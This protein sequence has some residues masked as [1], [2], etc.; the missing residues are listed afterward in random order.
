[1]IIARKLKLTILDEDKEKRKEQYKFIRDSQYAQYQGLNTC[2]GYLMSEYFRCNREIKSCEFKETQ[3]NITNSSPIFEGIEFGKGIDS[4]SLIT[5]KVKSDFK[6]ALKNGLASGERSCT[7][8]KRTFPLMTRG[9]DLKFRYESETSN[10][11]IVNWV[12]KIRFKV[13][14]GKRVNKNIAEL[15]YTLNKIINNEYKV[16]SSSLYF[17]INNNLMINLVIDIPNRNNEYKPEKNRTLGV[18]LG[19][20][21]PAYVCLN[22]N[23]YVKQTIGDINDS[24]KVKKQLQ[25][26]R[27]QLQ[28]ALALTNGGKGRKKKLQRLYKLDHDERN[29]VRTYNHAISKKIVQFARKNKCEYISLEDLSDEG[30]PNSILENWAYY[31]LQKFIEYKA[32]REGIKVKYV[33]PAYTSQ[34]CSCCGHIDKENRQSQEKFVCTKCGFELN[35]DHN[36]AINIARG[37]VVDD[38][39]D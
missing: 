31:E 30:F 14:L 35:A 6:I 9:R 39:I 1:M 24:L 25:E 10:E 8:Y 20:R 22:D 17:D 34:A 15:K 38:W 27:Y 16:K 4:K 2:M 26:R 13:I 36:A 33:N 3:K 32:E 23:I 21:Y 28:K 11:I 29:F 18:D 5:Q 19:I 37:G 12:N 7:N